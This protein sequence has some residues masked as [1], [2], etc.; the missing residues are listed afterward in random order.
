VH[1]SL[2][3]VV[4]WREGADIALLAPTSQHVRRQLHG[5]VWALVCDTPLPHVQDDARHSATT[6]R[7][8]VV[9]SSFGTEAANASQGERKRA[10]A[11]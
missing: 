5:D 3:P 10:I 6:H 2:E 7:R 1:G 11:D 4:G 9:A 8:F